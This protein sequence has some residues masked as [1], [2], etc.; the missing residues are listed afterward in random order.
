MAVRPVAF[1]VNTSSPQYTNL[2][3]WWPCAQSP[4]ETNPQRLFDLV[5]SNVY[6]LTYPGDPAGALIADS[7][8]TYCY[9]SNNP[10][11][12]SD[13]SGQTDF[14]PS[15]TQPFTMTALYNDIGQ[16]FGSGLNF[17]MTLY[18]DDNDS[19]WLPYVNTAG[20]RV[21]FHL[22]DAA[23]NYIDAQTT[24]LSVDGL[25][26][27][28]QMTYDGSGNENGIII[29]VDGVDL[30]TNRVSLGVLGGFTWTNVE[31]TV[32]DGLYRSASGGGRTCDV[33]W[34]DAVISSSARAAQRLGT[35][36]E[37]DL[38]GAA[39]PLNLRGTAGDRQVVLSWDTVTTAVSYNIYRGGTHG[40]EVLVKS[41]VT[42]TTYTDI[43]LQND[44]VYCYKVTAV[45]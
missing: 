38:Y 35:A 21:G 28:V 32:A 1:S 10:P 42:G 2:R 40:S 24:D 44:N 45:T 18:T 20:H 34:Y 43:G 6:T 25:W 39:G 16:A 31:I 11:F 33:R 36:T 26:H 4:P 29:Y 8:M 5:G 9:A 19:S 27:L 15:A 7:Q 23:G 22:A 13:I 14:L 30:T 41:G 3:N 37:W 17:G 12:S